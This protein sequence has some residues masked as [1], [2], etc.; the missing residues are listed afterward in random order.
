MLMFE[1]GVRG[2]DAFELDGDILVGDVVSAEIDFTETAA[3]DLTANDILITNTE[4][5]H[6]PHVSIRFKYKDKENN[7]PKP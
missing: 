7:I 2:I 5:L 1:L 6:A 4:L 3:T